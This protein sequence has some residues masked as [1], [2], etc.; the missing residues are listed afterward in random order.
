MFRFLG[1]DVDG[2]LTSGEI[3]YTSSGDELKT[4]DAKDGLGIAM[5]SR[6]GIVVAI[7]T[8]RDS[9]MV[10]RRAEDLGVKEVFTGVRNKGYIVKTILE[11][12]GIDRKEAVFI[13]DDII[14]IPA[15]KVVGFPVAVKDA[16]PE[17]K[18][19]ANMVTTRPGGKGA[20]R[21]VCEYIMKINGMWNSCVE[22][23]LEEIEGEE[24]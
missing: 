14:D 9:N 12:Y 22:K 17:V 6:C 7:I 4:F 23:L 20:G 10:K 5:C 21:E 1:M 8:G 13:G 16:P 15:M 2:V 3:T 24:F 11:K 18:N 19:Y